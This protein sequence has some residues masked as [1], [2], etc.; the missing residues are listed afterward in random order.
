[1]PWRLKW[2]GSGLFPRWYQSIF[3]IVS[4]L[5]FNGVNL[6]NNN[7]YS[8]CPQLS[9]PPFLVRFLVSQILLFCLMFPILM[10]TLSKKKTSSK[11]CHSLNT[12]PS[13]NFLHQISLPSLNIFKPNLP[14]NLSTLTKCRQILCQNVTWM[15]SRLIPVE[16]LLPSETSWA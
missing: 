16:F 7:P 4:V 1:M 11:P 2:V 6:F 12:L 13:Q 15:T 3:L 9:I 8:P 5:L 14:Q 10:I